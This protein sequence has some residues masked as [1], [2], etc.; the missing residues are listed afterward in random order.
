[1]ARNSPAPLNS[2]AATNYAALTKTAVVLLSRVSVNLANNSLT[3]KNKPITT[4]EASESDVTKADI[5]RSSNTIVAP[6]LMCKLCSLQSVDRAAARIHSKCHKEKKLCPVCGKRFEKL[7]LYHRH[8]KIHTE[9]KRYKCDK[10]GKSYKHKTDLVSHQFLHSGLRPYSCH[11]CKCKFRRPSTL[12]THIRTHTGERPY[13]C[14]HCS[15]SFKTSSDMRRHE[16]RHGNKKPHCCT[17]C[18]WKFSLIGELRRHTQTMHNP[19]KPKQYC[20]YNGG[21]KCRT[22]KIKGNE[23]IENG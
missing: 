16:A 3:P 17:L 1:M 6:K 23:E 7:P 8:L 12:E 4:G 15:L 14:S 9:D 21:Y 5:K 18:D 13:Q 2:S 11:L 20:P 22:V 19:E 10:C